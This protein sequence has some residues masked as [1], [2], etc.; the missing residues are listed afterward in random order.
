MGALLI[1]LVILIISVNLTI[2]LHELGHA[3]PAIILTKDQVSV[4]L[5]SYG[6]KKGSMQL[7]FGKL[8][9]W[10]K[11][12]SFIWI[13]GITI[14]DLK[15][16]SIRTQ[17]IYTL[18]GPLT[19]L[20]L[21]LIIWF[22]LYAFDQP[23]VIR[24][25][26]VCFSVLLMVVSL[27]NLIPRN[28]KIILSDGRTTS[29]DGTILIKLF[30][31]RKFPKES[32]KAIELY[33]NKQYE[34]AAKQ[35][36]KFLDG[37]LKHIG[38]YRHAILAYIF[39]KNYNKAEKLQ[40]DFEKEFKLNS[41]DYINAG[42]IKIQMK[43]YEQALIDY[44]KSLKIEPL[45]KI[46]LNNNGYTLSM[47][48]RYED[49][50]EYLNKAIELD[51]DFAYAYTNRGAAK[52]KLGQEEEGLADINY[53][54]KLDEKNADGYNQLGIYYFE[55]NKYRE[56]L[57]LFQKAKQLDADIPLVDYYLSEAQKNIG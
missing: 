11:K 43:Q 2:L 9:L 57:N 49:A 6:E 38:L 30:Q 41:N 12:N 50:L 52:I 16:N 28:K 44:E 25:F 37:G 26:L 32:I 55:K 46:S 45:N 7:K 54:I 23:G 35:L 18:L 36:E 4:F 5:G 40:K 10:I 51:S 1:F 29:N 42:F 56:A 22:F 24:S 3:I 8:E 33:N 39:M 34:A 27:G 31:Y 48:G 20:I 21:A 17:F 13:K 47:L 14:P 19:S 15:K 53:S